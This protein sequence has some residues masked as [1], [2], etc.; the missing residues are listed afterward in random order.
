MGIVE[1]TEE[2]HTLEEFF[3]SNDL[4]AAKV[5]VIEGAAATGKT[6][7]LHAFANRAVEAGATFLSASA[8]RAER[9]LPLSAVSQLF[10]GPALSATEIEDA[11]RLLGD[12]ALAAMAY[13]AGHEA[14]A[15]VHV[16]APILNRLC[17]SCCTSSAGRGPLASSW[18]SPSAFGRPGRI[19]SSTPTSSASPSPGSCG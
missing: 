11:E 1:R 10:R 3:S 18:C 5:V 19:R 15:A 8:S 4:G 14:D 12:G 13:G 2:L 9:D 7:L 17:S 16:P 6:S